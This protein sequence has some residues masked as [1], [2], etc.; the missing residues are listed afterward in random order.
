METEQKEEVK[1]VWLCPGC[2]NTGDWC[3]ALTMECWGSG[4]TGR[5]KEVRVDDPRAPS[6]VRPRTVQTK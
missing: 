3:E 2:G 1:T 5:G 4:G 6:Y